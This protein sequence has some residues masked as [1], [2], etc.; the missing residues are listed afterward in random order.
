MPPSPLRLSR[1]VPWC[2]ARTPHPVTDKYQPRHSVAAAH[3][4]PHSFHP[5]PA[6]PWS[7]RTLCASASLRHAR[8]CGCMYTDVSAF[9]VR[10][11]SRR[12]SSPSA[13][14]QF[15]RSAIPHW[16]RFTDPHLSVLCRL[17]SCAYGVSSDPIAPHLVVHE[18]TSAVSLWM[19]RPRGHHT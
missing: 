3:A 5:R 11:L 12:P 1:S 10:P 6:C 16:M 18:D 9:L 17:R 2:C 19:Y 14:F 4:L 8:E 7:V 15:S 13:R